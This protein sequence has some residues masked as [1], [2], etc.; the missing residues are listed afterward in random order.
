MTKILIIS[1]THQN[2]ILLRDVLSY[3]NDCQNIIHLGDEPDDLIYNADLIEDKT[4]HFVYGLY[5]PKWNK[6]NACIS[7][8]I[9]N[10]SFTIAHAKEILPI[11]TLK[12]QHSTHNTS[13]FCFGHTHNRYYKKENNSI[14]INPGHLKKEHDR[15]DIAGYVVI[16]VS[17]N[18]SIVFYDYKHNA[19]KDY[20]H[21]VIKV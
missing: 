21:I 1:D 19:L 4:I 3:N 9:D 8:T 5:H 7:F 20:E 2:D 18:I 16:T 12:T 13:I 17:E 15:G 11:K 6:N 14:Y 10:I